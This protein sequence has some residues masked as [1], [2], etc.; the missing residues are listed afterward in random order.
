MIPLFHMNT[1]SKMTLIFFI[2][3]TTAIFSQNRVIDSLKIELENHEVKDTIRVNTLNH[4]AF[5]HYR[6]DPPKAIAYIEESLELANKLNVKKFIAHSYYIKAVI[7]TEQAN[8]KIAKA[9]YE[10]A[11]QLY[12]L[13]EDLPG[14]KKCNNA[15]GV[16]NAYKGDFELALKHYKESLRISKQLGDRIDDGCLYNIGNVYSDIGDY[17]KALENFNQALEINKKEKDSVGILNALNSIANVYYQQGNYPLSLDYHN[18]SLDIAKK[19]KDSIGVF[20][21]NLNLGNLY[22]QQFLNDKA[23][24]YYNKALAINKAQYNTRNITALKNNIAGV[25]YDNEDYDKAIASF[26][27]SI[28]LSKEINDDVNLATALNGLGFVYFE[29]KQFSRALNYF[30]E[31]KDIC[32]ENNYSYDL[33]DSYHGVSDTQLNVKKYDLALVNA[34]KLAE[35]SEKYHSLKHKKIAYGLFSEIY[36]RKGDYKNA[37]K[38][39]EQYKILSDSL[40]NEENIKKLSEIEYEYKYKKVI[41]DAE[42]REVKL[43]KTV[44]TT[45]KSLEK[46]QRNLLTG[47]IT[48]VVISLVLAL[49]ILF[50]KLHNSKAEIKNIV[51]EQKLLRTQMTPHFIFNSLSV[52]QGMILNK[53][54]GKSIKYLS[55]FSKLLRITLENSREPSVLLS[56]ELEA[57]DNYISIQNIENEAIDFNLVVD[58]AIDT[59]KFKIPP[60]LIQPFVENSIE[61]AFKNKNISKEVTIKLSFKN[62]KLIC[63]I[64]DNGIGIDSSERNMNQNKKSLATTITS[65]R[66]KILSKDFKMKGAVTIE[67]RSRFNKQGTIVTIELPFI[68]I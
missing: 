11:I 17:S 34:K 18:Q 38:S 45:S 3:F 67:D 50:L 64:I 52:L 23:L 2:V 27:E 13:L 60:M 57:I 1:A 16:L 59:S 40:L 46:S 42:E 26:N 24:E 12:T 43:T 14:L 35:L 5:R 32:L 8:F 25:H 6:N 65:E 56:N 63:F 19:A 10:K 51:T 66:L 36:E 39:H 21:S 49:I 37:F 44:E 7:Y 22:R 62:D 55:K 54:E 53:E 68:K 47:V 9:N 61:H 15:L 29:T 30:Q 31:A 41:E 4:L 58:N 28:E 48:F 20:Q 33:L